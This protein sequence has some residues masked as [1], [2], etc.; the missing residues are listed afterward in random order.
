MGLLQAHG[1]QHVILSAAKD[2]R[3][4]QCAD[5]PIHP[6]VC[7]V[8]KTICIL[9]IRNRIPL[10]PAKSDTIA[11]NSGTVSRSARKNI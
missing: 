1:P 7:E 11:A 10:P 4:Y 9:L 5:W 8:F 3:I 2:P 6:D